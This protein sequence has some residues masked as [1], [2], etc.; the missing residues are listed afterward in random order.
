MLEILALSVFRR[1]L[2]A[3]IV[4]GI[5]YPAMGVFILS[6]ELV[7]ARFAVMHASLLGAAL[8]LLLGIDP[9]MAALAMALASGLAVARL[10]ETALPKGVASGRPESASGALGLVM[11]LSLAIA[12]IIFHKGRV[13]AIEA[14]NLFWGNILALRPSDLLLTAA[15]GGTIIAFTLLFFKEIRAVLHDRELARSSGM[16]ARAV[17]YAVIVLVCLGLGMAMRLTGALLADALTILPALAARNLR[18]GLGRT[19]AWGALFGVASNLG[20]F[21]LALAF[22][23]PTG[24]AIILAAAFIVGATRLIG[25]RGK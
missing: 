3:L 20:G 10:G 9:T 11:T 24:P 7:P 16:P 23:L 6:L 19:L 1:A 14:F 12:F 21:A 17:Y 25:A 8:G 22:D 15:T 4:S 18:L 2:A 13:N 5:A